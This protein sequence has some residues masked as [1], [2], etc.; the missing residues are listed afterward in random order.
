MAYPLSSEKDA[1]R[2]S[3]KFQNN[4]EKITS[5]Y[6]PRANWLHHWNS[7]KRSFLN[8]LRGGKKIKNLIKNQ[9]FSIVKDRAMTKKFPKW[10]NFGLDFYTQMINQVRMQHKDIYL[11]VSFSKTR[12]RINKVWHEIHRKHWK[13]SK[14]EMKK[15]PR[16]TARNQE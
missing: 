4:L 1:G 16:M 5:V 3:V 8:D 10:N 7:R 13:W 15:S 2:Q 9:K 6:V 12:M 11:K 14:T